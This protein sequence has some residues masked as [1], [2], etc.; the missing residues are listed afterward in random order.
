MNI[1]TTLAQYST[2]TVE[3]LT[4]EEIAAVQSMLIPFFAYIFVLTIFAYVISALLVSR[5]FKK[6]GLA[7]WPAWV[8]FY[9]NWRLFEI[10]GQRGALSLLLAVPILQFIGIIF[11]YIALYHIGLKLQ[12]SGAFILLAILLPIVWMAV[13]AFDDSKWDETKSAAPN[14]AKG[15]L[16]AQP[17]L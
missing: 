9:N 2:Q 10:G 14:L 8:P 5:I 6:A 3:P 17:K 7:G 1:F 4:P 12:K 13:L 16:P 11:Y 15:P